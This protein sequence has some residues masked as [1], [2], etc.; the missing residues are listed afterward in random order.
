[1]DRLTDW[2]YRTT[3]QVDAATLQREHVDLVFDGLDTYAEVFLNEQPVLTA[4][5]MF[6]HWRSRRETAA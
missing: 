5:N 1:M 3:F 2:E 6:R 4:D